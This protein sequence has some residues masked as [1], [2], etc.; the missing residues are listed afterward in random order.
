MHLRNIIFILF[1]L[2][3]VNSY[4]DSQDTY[5]LENK[6]TLKKAGILYIKGVNFGRAG[7]LDSALFYTQNAINLFESVLQTD[8]ILLA[9]TF[10]SLGIINKLLGK[11]DEA[12]ICYNKS[13]E[14]YRLK[15]K[16][17]LL[18]YIYGNKANI[19]FIQQDYTKARDFHLRAINIFKQ[20]S[21][22]YKNQ[23]ASTYNNLGNIYRKNSDY[24]NAIKYY[25]KSLKLKEENNTSYSTLGNLAL[26]YEKINN[27]SEAL[28]YYINTLKTTIKYYGNNST[29]L[30][31]NYTNY[32]NFLEIINRNNESQK[33]Y[34]LALNIY[35]SNFIEKH[36]D[37][38]NCYNEIGE[39]YQKQNKPD[40]ALDYF[41]KSLIALSPEFNDTSIS[42]NP[43]ID[44]VLSKTHLLSS[45]K[46]KA[47]TLSILASQNKNTANHKLSLATYDIAIETI[48]QIRSGYLSEESKLFL[49]DNEFETFSNALQTSFELY[50]LTN[51]QK[52]LE[53]AFNY[54][55]SGKS[56]ILTEALKNIHALNIGGIPDNL[57]L[58]EK[59]LEKSIWAYEEL[60]YEENK[61]KTPD[62]N[63]LA[64]W[65]KYLFE[66]KQ[67][68]AEFL[69]SL[70]NNFQKYHSLKYSSQH[71]SINDLQSKLSAKDAL[72]EYYLYNNRVYIFYIDKKESVL[73]EQE[74]NQ[75]F[76]NHLNDILISLS[77]NNFSNHGYQEFSK[78]QE[79]SFYLYSKLIQPFEDKINNKNLI[80][81]P[82]GKLAYLPFSSLTYENK[83]FNKINYR[84]LSY[85]IYKNT[86][87]YSYSANFLLDEKTNEKTDLSKLAGFA[88]TYDNIEG[89][90]DNNLTFR[91]KY[92]EKLFP[93]KGITEE[94]EIINELIG[95]DVFIDNEATEYNFKKVASGYDILH[96]AMHTIMDD[97]N[98]MYSKMV[99][100]QT[101]DTTEDGFLNT[102]ELYNMNLNARM[103]VLSSCNSGSGILHRG[104]GVLSMARGFVYSGCPSII[105][106]LWSVEDNSGVKL[107]TSFYS[108]LLKG[109]NKSQS[110]RKSK[111][112]FI[113]KADQLRAH[114]YFW[115]GYVVIGNNESLFF[116]Y[117]KYTIISGLIILFIVFGIVLKR[118]NKF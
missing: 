73:F 35:K 105:M 46:N 55:E 106:T 30:A 67:E 83:N 99:F 13:E 56:A 53:K 110:I 27:Y 50:K 60:I 34:E 49:A 9:N 101:N 62:N 94:V 102:Y 11:Y 5:Y 111:I 108:Y 64:Y 85:F 100:T 69:Q 36:P 109:K 31:L 7:D 81:I 71:F 57:I 76:Y 75:P 24:V 90:Q 80:I 51:E 91:Q 59:Q 58:K 61:K 66:K 33:Y 16:Q 17:S 14:I 21:I 93:L 47:F 78:F 42:S 6:E 29:R 86:I 114:P 72:I 115:S 82:D 25:N 84:D 88:P 54:S 70:E 104:E 12:I 32:A 28:D 68:Y 63:K 1:L 87:N 38:S 95:G 4:A 18:A 112:D 41:Q 15:S 107:M 20:D 79:S 40:L 77:N 74:I 116:P 22:A 2:I 65:S 3:S 39:F 52:Y 10:Q 23:L 37:L 97:I 19:F 26:C 45:L 44:K 98:P 113:K 117:K 8:S 103:A 92:R 89:L 118:Y 43:D 96:L 48:N